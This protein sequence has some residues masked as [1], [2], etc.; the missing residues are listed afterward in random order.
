MEEIIISPIIESLIETLKS[1]AEDEI[2][3]T[4][5][6]DTELT[7]LLKSFSIIQSVVEDAEEKQFASDKVKQWLLRLKSVVS[8]A[9]DVSE[10][11]ISSA[12]EAK[13]AE[14][15]EKQEK[16]PESGNA[17]E[18][19][20]LCPCLHHSETPTSDTREKFRRLRRKVIRIEKE[21]RRLRLIEAHK[22]EVLNTMPTNLP[23]KAF[24]FAALDNIVLGREEDKKKL[25]EE[26]IS[27][28]F[29]G[30]GPSVIPI[31]A[32]DGMGKTMF[33]RLV[34]TSKEIE[35]RF[36]I[37]WWFR[38]SP[39][40]EEEKI[41]GE[42][43]MDTLGF[44]YMGSTGSK[45]MVKEFVRKRRFLLVIDNVRDDNPN[46]RMLL[47]PFA[48]R[49]KHS[50]I[51]ITTKSEEVASVLGTEPPFRLEGLS[52]DDCAKLFI[53]KAFDA[54][55]FQRCSNLRQIGEIVDK[56]GGCPLAV[57]ALG[58]FLSD[59]RDET[60][61]Q[62]VLENP[63]WNEN[64]NSGVAFRA[65]QICYQNFP[66]SSKL[67]FRYCSLFPRD[68][69]YLGNE[70]LQLWIAEGYRQFDNVGI[71][72][73]DLVI[74]S[75]MSMDSVWQA[76]LRYRL[77]D[78]AQDL[79]EAMSGKEFVRIVEGIK[80]IEIPQGARHSSFVCN[81]VRPSVRLE[82]LC[83]DTN[84]DS[85]RSFLYLDLF[86]NKRRFWVDARG[87]FG[88]EQLDLLLQCKF[89]RVLRLQGSVIER[90]PESIAKLKLLRFLDLSDTTLAELPVSVCKLY[91]LRT[92]D[93][94]TCIDIREVP[95]DIKNLINLRFL[96]LGD[97]FHSIDPFP[98]IGNL[99][100]L[101]WLPSFGVRRETGYRISELK[102]MSDLKGAI[103]IF[104]L[105]EVGSGEEAEEANMKYKP[106]LTD[107]TLEWWTRSGDRDANIDEEV[108]EA[109]EPH[110][111]LKR[112]VLCGY[113]G[114]CLASWVHKLESLQ[115]LEVISCPKLAS[116]PEKGLPRTLQ[117]LKIISCP[118]LRERC[119]KETGED[120]HK[121]ADIP[122]VSIE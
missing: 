54:E 68:Y 35:E 98:H 119:K 40:L 53:L 108:L 16:G 116:L 14:E 17:K 82:E 39:D 43:F 59:K 117:T 106:Y 8:D 36:K 47:K 100:K 48:G 83:K 74:K 104:N 41:N 22:Q 105:Q 71:V 122:E 63:I 79:A 72:F 61:W 49:H 5:G 113:Q 114:R 118:L 89:L 107:L 18:V 62:N 90:I 88:D 1:A 121:I 37:R 46:W 93:L 97:D 10:E 101:I 56:C 78:V 57:K 67:C 45:L 81:T 4:W 64:N 91:N 42:I 99:K 55:T 120:W 23:E 94:R 7:R 80:P 76:K 50:K 103:N 60:E 12:A 84:K 70:L 109:L 26:L 44:V 52:R 32:P 30:K 73:S 58:G 75:F 11:F 29:S 66:A 27:S 6:V 13:V 24:K 3:F 34:Y 9:E 77:H 2:K 102:N 69:C 19:K 85:L 20:S 28:K 65:L 92:L 96:Y 51:I 115:G 38:A 112:L 87:D 95:T 86:H 111:N 15:V 25:S 110:S 33:A 31:V 21:C